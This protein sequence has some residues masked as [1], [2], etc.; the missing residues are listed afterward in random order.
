MILR[1][2]LI[3]AAVIAILLALGAAFGGRNEMHAGEALA[4][5]PKY[6]AGAILIALIEEGFFRAFLLG[7]MLEDF[8]RTAALVIQAAVYALAHLVRSPTRFYLASFDV[9][10]G[11]HNL[12]ASLAQ[13][14]SSRSSAARVGRTLSAWAGAG[15][16]VPGHRQCLFL[17]GTACR[18]GDRRKAMAVQQR[19]WR[20]TSALDRRLRSAGADKRRGGVGNGA[21]IARAG[22][23]SHRPISVVERI[24]AADSAS[25][26]PVLARFNFV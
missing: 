15:R 11:F 25:E 4:R 20:R 18:P 22:A 8:G 23:A 2:L 16:G 17:G 26:G 1:G 10:A 7:G 6:V 14:S 12:Y 3:A 5:V 19:A 21:D 9:T 13:L 24:P